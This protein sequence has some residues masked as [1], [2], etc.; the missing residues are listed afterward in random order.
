DRLRDTNR[1]L[2]L[3]AQMNET[4]QQELQAVMNNRTPPGQG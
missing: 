1:K 4:L 2:H 3:F